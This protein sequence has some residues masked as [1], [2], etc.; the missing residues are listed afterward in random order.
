MKIAQ[1]LVSLFVIASLV[2]SSLG[3]DVRPAASYEQPPSSVTLRAE[4]LNVQPET[5]DVERPM[6][7]SPSGAQPSTFSRQPSSPWASDPSVPPGATTRVSISSPGR[8]ADGRAQV[9]SGDGRYVA[10]AARCD[11]FPD[12]SVDFDTPHVFVYDR[13][14]GATTRVSVAS[15]ALVST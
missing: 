11:I 14:S 9:I 7:L 8:S 5:S 12:C 2:L 4:S 13:Q 1:P 3:L 10:F 15:D 6:S